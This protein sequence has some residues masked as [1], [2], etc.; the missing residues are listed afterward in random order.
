AVYEREI[1][2]YVAD[3]PWK[4]RNEYIHLLLDPSEEKV[5]ALIDPQKSLT[6]KIKVLNLLQMQKYGMYMFTSC[7]WF[8]ED[9]SRIETIQ[10]LRYA[11]RAIEFAKEV[12][13]NLE[14]EFVRRL[15]L[16]QSK[17]PALISGRGVYQKFIKPLSHAPY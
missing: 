5:D 1:R 13:T 6:D 4:I 10:L 3:D 12:G 2:R 17:D 15:D 11:A 14:A 7:G 16:A 8:F 9:V